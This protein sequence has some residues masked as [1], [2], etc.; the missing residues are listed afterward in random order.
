[1][2]VKIRRVRRCWS[3]FPLPRANHFGY[4][5]LTHSH[6]TKHRNKKDILAPLY[7]G[8]QAAS[9]C[10]ACRSKEL[11]QPKQHAPKTTSTTHFR[12]YF[13]GDWDVHWGYGIL[14]HGHIGCYLGLDSLSILFSHR[15]F[16]K[17]GSV[18]PECFMVSCKEGSLE[19]GKVPLE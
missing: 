19:R 18:S 6:L 9:S 15:S 17:T 12:T 2:W 7:P 5:F 8:F 10:A 4:L 1:M 16:Q 14:T 13:S 3:M 11:T